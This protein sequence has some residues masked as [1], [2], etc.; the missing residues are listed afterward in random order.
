MNWE[1]MD[2]TTAMYGLMEF[3]EFMKESG[4]Y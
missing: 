3:A 4:V 1:G 2:Y